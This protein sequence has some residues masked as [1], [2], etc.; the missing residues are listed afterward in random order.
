MSRIKEYKYENGNEDEGGCAGGVE[1]GRA[2][3]GEGEGR[4]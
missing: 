4:A 2:R 3:G 1:C